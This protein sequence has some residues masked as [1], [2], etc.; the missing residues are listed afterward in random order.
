MTN[1][2]HRCPAEGPAE[3]L[4]ESDRGTL[5]WLARLPLLWPEAIAQLTGLR[6]GA[7]VYRRLS[8]LRTAGLVQ[9]IQPPL[10]P[11]RARRLFCLSQRGLALFF[12]HVISMA[13]RLARMA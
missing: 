6:G 2:V 9:T 13:P 12:A 7:S 4:T 11:G 8:R 1:R 10:R 3:P 5:L